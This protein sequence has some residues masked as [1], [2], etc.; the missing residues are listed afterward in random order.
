MS[1]DRL[2]TTLRTCERNQQEFAAAMLGFQAAC[3]SYN[4]K[5]AE[6]LEAMALGAMEAYFGNMASAYKLREA[7]T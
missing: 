1:T 6:R 3:L 2:L 7:M 4:W 5:E